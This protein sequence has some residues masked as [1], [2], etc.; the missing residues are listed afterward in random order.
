MLETELMRQKERCT[1]KNRA[2][3][4]RERD[5]RRE[6]LVARRMALA[7]RYALNVIHLLRDRTDWF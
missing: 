5:L 3:N 4:A 1:G 7:R 2:L 6:E